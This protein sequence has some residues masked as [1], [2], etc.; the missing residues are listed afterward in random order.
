M[1]A[2]GVL[3]VEFEVVRVEIFEGDEGVITLRPVMCMNQQACDDIR[4]TS[5]AGRRRNF[6]VGQ[7]LVLVPKDEKGT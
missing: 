6:S 7:R 1:P 2:W 3:Q 5:Y 4:I